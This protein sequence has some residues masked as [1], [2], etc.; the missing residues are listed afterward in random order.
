VE[1][2]VKARSQI[3]AETA[4]MKL[5]APEDSHYLAQAVSA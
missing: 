2:W 4:Q 1:Q 5:I 3:E